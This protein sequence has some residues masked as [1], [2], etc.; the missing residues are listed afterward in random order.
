M[1][2][3]NEFLLEHIATMPELSGWHLRRIDRDKCWPEWRKFTLQLCHT[4]FTSESLPVASIDNGNEEQLEE[5]L[6]N[7]IEAEKNQPHYEEEALMLYGVE[8]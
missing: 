3:T 6:K 2:I 7:R 5:Y 1:E 4:S 8:L